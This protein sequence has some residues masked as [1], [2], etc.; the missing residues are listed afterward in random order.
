[1]MWFFGAIGV[2][3]VVL[4]IGLKLPPK[5][6]PAESEMLWSREYKQMYTDCVAY[7]EELYQQKK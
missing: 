6:K 3:A 1:M 5:R 2:S 4:F 7:A